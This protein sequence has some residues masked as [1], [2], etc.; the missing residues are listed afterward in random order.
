MVCTQIPL[1]GGVLPSG[2]SRVVG[3]GVGLMHV[4]RDAISG[5]GQV[6][7]VDGEGIEIVGEG[8]EGVD[9]LLGGEPLP[10]EPVVLDGGM[11]IVGDGVLLLLGVCVCVVEA[12]TVAGAIKR[13][14]KIPMTRKNGVIIVF[15]SPLEMYA[16]NL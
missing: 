10:P 11:L 5:F 16:L 7:V 9:G 4:P 15:L 14:A 3:C 12:S 2:H 8:V 13:I 1:G 6:I